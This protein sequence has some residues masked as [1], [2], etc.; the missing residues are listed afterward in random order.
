LGIN[1]IAKVLGE[2][3]A[4]CNCWTATSFHRVSQTSVWHCGMIRSPAFVSPHI[5]SILGGSAQKTIEIE[6]PRLGDRITTVPAGEHARE[7]GNKAFSE[8]A[9]SLPHLS[10]GTPLER[11]T[12][13]W[14]GM[15]ELWR[16]FFDATRGINF[17][18]GAFQQACEYA[19]ST[20]HQDADT[21]LRRPLTAMVKL[22]F[23]ELNTPFHLFI[24][25]SGCYGWWTGHSKDMLQEAF[26]DLVT[27][28]LVLD[29]EARLTAELPRKC[30]RTNSICIE[31][32]IAKIL[33]ARFGIA[34]A[35]FDTCVVAESIARDYFGWAW[36][37]LG[38]DY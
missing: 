19:K 4:L 29:A 8:W 28:S 37:R 34:V 5:D 26:G 32:I 11:S 18:P 21:M 16:P 38:V 36:G 13:A 15:F 27:F 1:N 20:K 23:V 24:A 2:W 9:K 6:L 22:H 33:R 17:L 30:D 3:I 14:M 31:T 35:D 7:R 10:G 25:V 12:N